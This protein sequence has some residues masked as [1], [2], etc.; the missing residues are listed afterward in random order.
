MVR[1]ITAA[2]STPRRTACGMRMS[3][4]VAKMVVALDR[5]RL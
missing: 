2:A 3:S 4:E 5:A 1:G